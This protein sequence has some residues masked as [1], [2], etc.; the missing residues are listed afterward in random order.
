MEINNYIITVEPLFK[1][2][3]CQYSSIEGSEVVFGFECNNATMQ[4]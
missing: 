3:K 4:S 1:N 2:F